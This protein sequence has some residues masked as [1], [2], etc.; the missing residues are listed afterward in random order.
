MAFLAKKTDETI[1]ETQTQVPAAAP[2][3]K[4]KKEP[5]VTETK[6]TEPKS[7]PAAAPAPI[8]ETITAPAPIEEPKKEEPVIVPTDKNEAERA[9]F[10]AM[11][12]DQVWS[13]F[14]GQDGRGHVSKAIRYL[15]AI[16]F[17][18]SEV[19]KLTGKR[20]QHVRNVLVEDARAAEAAK[21]RTATK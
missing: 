10:K 3:T 6:V 9:K 12:V 17:D 14:G 19:A 8:A 4:G 7:E 5:K 21:A 2:A 13:H 18:R 20:Y 16:G 11:A 1:T 15:T